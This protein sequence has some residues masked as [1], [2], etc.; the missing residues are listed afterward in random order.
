MYL[1]RLTV[2]AAL[3]MVGAL[4]RQP[5]IIS[6][7]Q[8]E[9]LCS[10]YTVHAND[11]C[12]S[13]GNDLNVTW[14]QLISWN[15]AI[16]KTCSNLAT[17]VNTDLC[18]SNPLGDYA[19]PSNT[20]G[21]TSI[22]TTP[23]PVA[24]PTADGTNSYCGQYYLIDTG[25]DCSTI[26][27]KFGI[28]L[29]DFIFLNPE[30]W[31][32]CT[33]L[34]KDYY[35]CVQPVGTITTY[36]GHPESTTTIP[37]VETSAT[38]APYIDILANYT[39]NVTTVPLAN[40]SRLDCYEYTYIQNVSD[41]ASMSCWGLATFYDIER[42]E[43]VLWN[44]SLAQD[45]ENLTSSTNYKYDCELSE[46]VSYCVLLASPTLTSSGAIQTPNP[47][48]AG[49]VANCTEWYLMETFSTCQDVLALYGITLKDFY[50]FNPSVGST[51][52]TM[53]AGTYYCVS[54]NADGT[55]PRDDGYTVTTT[56]SSS[57]LST[58]TGVTTPSPVQTGMVSNCNEFY[59]V[60]SGDGCWAIA[61]DHGIA[62]DDFYAWNPAVGSDCSGLE[63]EVYVCVGVSQTASPTTTTTASST[64]SSAAIVTPTPTQSGMVDGCKSFYYV[65]SGDGC[66]SIAND[67]GIEL[68]DFYDWNPA[69]GTDCAS[70]W[71]DYYVCVGV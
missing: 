32:N 15:S 38:A 56:T 50:A 9:S 58:T 24:T 17:L 69:V 5:P 67:H 6:P 26:T 43:L 45:G 28:D 27:T 30:I 16:D 57:A 1:S 53:A 70:L 13:I 51:C 22:A 35:Y 63:A 21:A 39:T 65:V 31:E 29:D 52:S 71:P 37:F 8:L 60:V 18:V 46:S 11:T 12:I 34:M 23:A 42:E 2:Q 7:R 3:A 41:M 14:A 20:V 40:G 55:A 33:N 66:W 25:D 48:A 64:T 49:E 68:A 36:S 62:L 4:A 19:M 10:T 47:R 54:T 61:N 44:P 59:Y